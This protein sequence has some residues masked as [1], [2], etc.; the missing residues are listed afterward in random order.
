[1][2]PIRIAAIAAGEILCP[3]FFLSALSCTFFSRAGK[4]RISIR[5][6]SMRIA[7]PATI[8][9]VLYDIFADATIPIRNGSR[10]WLRQMENFVNRLAT[11]GLFT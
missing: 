2:N 6:P 10:N 5:I 11:D 7:I 1:M 3:D 9:I 4:G 8:K